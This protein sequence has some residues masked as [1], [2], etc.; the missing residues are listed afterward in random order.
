MA[1][2]EFTCF[3]YAALNK[4]NA[5]YSSQGL[6]RF[7]AR[8]ILAHE[9]HFDVNLVVTEDQ[10]PKSLAEVFGRNPSVQLVREPICGSIRITYDPTGENAPTIYLTED[11]LTNFQATVAQLI[12]RG[13]HKFGIAKMVVPEKFRRIRD[14]VSLNDLNR[15]AGKFPVLRKEIAKTCPGIFETKAKN[16]KNSFS[17]NDF[18]KLVQSGIVLSGKQTLMVFLPAWTA[19]T[20]L[21]MRQISFHSCFQ[22]TAIC[23][24]WSLIRN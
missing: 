19:S 20:W 7:Y 16:L 23:S 15:L 10:Q 22:R 11:E 3:Y 9:K 8:H 14:P 18:F 17:Y 13:V 1:Y 2:R 5:K 24:G 4:A 6:P 12:S 21:S